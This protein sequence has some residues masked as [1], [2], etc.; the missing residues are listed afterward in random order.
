[1]PRIF[2]CG[3]ALI[4]FVPREIGQDQGFLALP[5]GSPFNT[6][7]AAA[8]AGA[9]AHF[10][11]PL[12]RDFFGD[13]LLAD[14]QAHGVA[15]TLTPRSDD[16]STLAFVDMSTGE[17]HYAFFDKGSAAANMAPTAEG[18][19][20][21]P[22]DIL[23]VG[24]ISLIPRPGADNILDFALNS[25]AGMI[26]AFD[27][28]VRPSI[29]TDR[30]AWEARVAALFDHAAIIKISAEDLDFLRPGQ[31]REDFAAERIA[32]G[33]ALVVI[34]GGAE[35]ALGVTAAGRAQIAAPRVRVADTVGA[36]DT[37][38]G[39]LLSGVQGEGC[40]SAAAI[41]GLGDDALARMLTVAA[42]AA[43]INCTRTG[44]QPPTI[45]ETRAAIAAGH[46]S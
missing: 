41:S 43:A 25:A 3:E 42:W 11:G 27:P 28:N 12:S 8:R 45:G 18:L 44:C 39:N 22:G 7:K 6:A 19:S 21:E 32:A 23:A 9:E 4:D 34:T 10:L 36:G 29:L 26:L 35:G 1:M 2:V 37:F 17:P 5:G 16:P 13:R 38:M 40:A 14:L 46:I 15:T 33:A 24:S 30:P 31:S 20:P